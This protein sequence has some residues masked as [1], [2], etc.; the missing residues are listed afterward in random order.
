[1]V[2]E[3][4]QTGQFLLEYSDSTV[5]EESFYCSGVNWGKCHD[6]MTPNMH[7]FLF[8]SSLIFDTKNGIFL[9]G[10]VI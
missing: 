1:M 3:S 5:I 4:A 9:R 10:E 6:W 7:C 2:T 8:L